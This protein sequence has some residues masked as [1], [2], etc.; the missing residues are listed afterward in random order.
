MA[1]VSDLFIERLYR[2][3][4]QSFKK[5]GTSIMLINQEGDVLYKIMPISNYTEARFYQLAYQNTLDT[6]NVYL[7][8][9]T[10]N[11]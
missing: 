7:D 9:H 4:D 5:C 3:S 1:D 8:I 2:I 6:S 10:G 11:N